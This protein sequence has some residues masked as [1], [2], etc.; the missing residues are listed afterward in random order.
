MIEKQ[1]RT[2]ARL[3]KPTMKHS[4]RAGYGSSQKLSGSDT[5]KKELGAILL[6]KQAI[7]C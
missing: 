1:K 4:D 2:Q 3:Q 7:F 5:L 6:A